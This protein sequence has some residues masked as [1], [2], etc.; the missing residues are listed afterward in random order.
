[1]QPKFLKKILKKIFLTLKI[2]LKTKKAACFSV[3][4]QAA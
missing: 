1:M 4:K 3:K 2:A